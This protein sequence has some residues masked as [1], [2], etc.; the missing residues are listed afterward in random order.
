M[1]VGTCSTGELGL[2]VA[3][4]RR[5]D[6]GSGPVRELDRRI[7]HR[8][9]TAGH[10]HDATREPTWPEMLRPVLVDR[11]TT[12]G[13]QERHAEARAQVVRRVV[14]ETHDVRDRQDGVLL[15]R[16]TGRALLRRLPDPH[17][18]VLPGRVGVRSDRVDDP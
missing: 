3:A 11:Q 7:A 1:E 13:R 17:T 8:T 18:T 16:A 9:G 4:H 12:V 10:E 2:L 15:R 14:R 5:D 6:S